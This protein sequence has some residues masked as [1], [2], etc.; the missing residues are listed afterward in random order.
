M[1]RPIGSKS[2]YKKRNILKYDQIKEL[3]ND[4]GKIPNSE[5]I[6]KY[7]ISKGQLKSI[8]DSYN[9]KNKNLSPFLK[10]RIL[11][12]NITTIVSGIYIICR[13]DFHKAYI[14]SSHDVYRRIRQHIES[15]KNN[16]HTNTD[17]Q[18]DFNQYEFYIYIIEECQESELLKK[19]YDI[20]NKI[21]SNILYNKNIQNE[22]ISVKEI[23]ET[24]LSKIDKKDNGCWEW[25]GK[26]NQDG[27]GSVKKDNKYYLVHRISYMYHYD[28]YPYLVH[29]KCKNRK[30]CNPDHLES[31]SSKVN[32]RQEICLEKSKLFPYKD[33]I[34]EK[35]KN[36]DNFRKIAQDLEIKTSSTAVFNFV[37][38]LKDLDLL[39]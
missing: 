5:I 11:D 38:K 10:N 29:H 16:T 15:L 8:R 4:Y 34:I 19:E 23:F 26:I 7:N 25:T 32:A 27:Y 3:I 30:C 6:K 2:V 18:N 24:I 14:G 31:V 22:D 1:T 39:R 20:I 37:K 17:F 12:L 13:D 9:L 21:N 33:I 36:G 28:T 35:I